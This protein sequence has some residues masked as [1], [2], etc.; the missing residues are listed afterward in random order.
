[1]GEALL[2]STTETTPGPGLAPALPSVPQGPRPTWCPQSRQ[3]RAFLLSASRLWGVS[4]DVWA[5]V[6]QFG[7][8]L[9]RQIDSGKTVNY[10]QSGS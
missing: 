3:L 8:T 6:N 1:M 5:D 7:Q 10:S 4:R 9:T 2:H